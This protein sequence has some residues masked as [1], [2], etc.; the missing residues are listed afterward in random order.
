M[1][2]PT[3]PTNGQIYGEYKYNS[4]IG[5]WKK[6]Y[7]QRDEG[8]LGLLS[9][10]AYN[11]SDSLYYREFAPTASGQSFTYDFTSV[12]PTNAKAVHISAFVHGFAQNAATYANVRVHFSDTNTFTTGWKK[13]TLKMDSIGY[14]PASGYVG[15]NIAGPVALNSSRLFY[16]KI[17]DYASVHSATV[18]VVLIG[19]YT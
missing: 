6:N 14:I 10:F 3:S 7:V 11:S 19:Y 1:A 5:V 12:L 8:S 2:F 16:S 15:G 17:E 13:N 18:Y 4:G 9:L